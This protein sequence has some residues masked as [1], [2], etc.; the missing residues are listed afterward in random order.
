MRGD[1]AYPVRRL[2]NFIP[3]F[4]PLCTHP[5]RNVGCLIIVRLPVEVFQFHAE[6]AQEA[7][8]ALTRKTVACRRSGQDTRCPVELILPSPAHTAIRTRAFL[9]LLVPWIDIFIAHTG[10][11]V[12]GSGGIQARGDVGSDLAADV[13]PRARLGRAWRN[14][15]RSPRSDNEQ[16]KGRSV[17]HCSVLIF[18]EQ[19]KTM[20]GAHG[21]LM[22]S[23]GPVVVAPGPAKAHGFPRNDTSGSR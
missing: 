2:H 22:H 18:Q 23:A 5:K 20:T 1:T 13:E 8:L 12:T 16:Q 4:L 11:V 7:V 9:V 15:P 21:G 19:C 3:E 10:P 6:T 14:H 17:F